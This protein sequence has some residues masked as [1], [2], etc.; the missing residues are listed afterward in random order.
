M[1]L[2]VTIAF[3]LGVIA[4]LLA[5]IV[6]GPRSEVVYAQSS[7]GTG[8]FVGVT[9]NATPGGRNILW[10]VEASS[11]TPHLALYEW[12]GGR[13]RLHASR[14]IRYDFMFDQWPAKSN[15]QD[16]SVQEAYDKTEKQRKRGR[17]D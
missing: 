6:F 15:A 8:G 12:E 9:G 7:S 13:L 3:F 14:N 2:Q 17:S 10:L 5:V 16:P 1:R 4:T 11:D